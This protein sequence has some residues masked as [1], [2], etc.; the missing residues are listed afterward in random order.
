MPGMLSSIAK[1]RPERPIVS[2]QLGASFVWVGGSAL[3]ALGWACLVPL[4]REASFLG[5]LLAATIVLYDAIHKRTSL[6]PVLMAACRFLLYL[7]AAA[8]AVGRG[9]FPAL[10]PAAALAAYVLGLSF[11]ARREST[12]GRPPRWPI[13]FLFVPIALALVRHPSLQ[14]CAWVP[15]LCLGLWISWCLLAG[16]WRGLSFLPGGVAGL[17]A[18]IALVDWL[19]ASATACQ[20]GLPFAGLFLLALLLQ[21]VAPA[22]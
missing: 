21:R 22:T 15:G 10:W 4:G 1:Y 11:V 8:A 12:S 7:T 19:A 13:P 20:Q 14:G 3:L 17:L 6:A 18:G 16:R 2:G 9:S 5:L